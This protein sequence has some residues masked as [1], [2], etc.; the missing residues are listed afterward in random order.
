MGQVCSAVDTASSCGTRSAPAGWR[1]RRVGGR[2]VLLE[3]VGGDGEALALAGPA[4]DA[5]GEGLDEQAAVAV[6]DEDHGGPQGGGVGDNPGDLCVAGGGGCGGGVH[7]V[8]TTRPP[9][10]VN[11]GGRE[12]PTGPIRQGYPRRSDGPTSGPIAGAGSC[13]RS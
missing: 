5:S 11:P 1:G 6:A 12:F 13:A 9:G 4:A 8:D 2:S 3:E 10:D 7:E